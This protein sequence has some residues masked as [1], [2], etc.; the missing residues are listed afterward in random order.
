MLALYR[1]TGQMKPIKVEL[2]VDQIHGP[3]NIQNV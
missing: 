1:D 3:T 2:E